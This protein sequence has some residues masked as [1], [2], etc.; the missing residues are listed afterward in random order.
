M[1]LTIDRR[2]EKL[3]YWQHQLQ[4]T[5]KKEELN[6]YGRLE[7][8]IFDF[9]RIWICESS[10]SDSSLIISVAS[11]R[12]FQ[13]ILLH[14]TFKKVVFYF[15]WWL[16]CPFDRSLSVKD[17]QLSNRSILTR[18]L[19]KKLK[20]SIWND[21]FRKKKLSIGSNDDGICLTIKLNPD[22]KNVKSKFPHSMHQ[23]NLNHGFSTF[24][25]FHR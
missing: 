15:K 24:A 18:K 20:I 11:L 22:R 12:H 6:R 1:R 3:A 9:W 21:G 10:H 8:N 14:Q 16:L 17:C 13:F 5:T 2:R 25:A 23:I 19:K 7:F 4:A